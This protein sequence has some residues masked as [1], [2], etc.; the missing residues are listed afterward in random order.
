MAGSIKPLVNNRKELYYAWE[1]PDNPGELLSGAAL[2]LMNLISENIEGKSTTVRSEESNASLLPGE[3]KRVGEE[4]EGTLSFTARPGTQFEDM[5]AFMLMSTWSTELAISSNAITFAASDNSIS[6]TP[7]S[8]VQPRTWINLWRTGAVV[9]DPNVGRA[10]V[11]S[12]P[13]STKCILAYIVISDETAGTTVKVRGQFIRNGVTQ[14]TIMLERKTTDHATTPFQAL[15]ANVCESMQMS[16]GARGLIK[17]TVQV[18]GDWPMDKSASSISSETSL[19]ADTGEE[20]DASTNLVALHQNGSLTANL[21]SLEFTHGNAQDPVPLGGTPRLDSYSPGTKA[22]TGSLDGY[23]T[24]TETRAAWARNFADIELHVAL[25]SARTNRPTYI[26][27]FFLLKG[28]K[29]GSVGKEG[30]KGPS[31]LKLPFESNRPADNIWMQVCKLT[32]A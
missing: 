7:L 15:P 4:S 12:K 30:G 26:V 28:T 17:V 10:F 18:K 2:R 3:M 6:G 8:A 19:A 27:T 21:S 9:T 25:M 32:D 16:I 22:L 5:L 20:L 24:S 14:R 11:V 29:D 13:T 1:D 23:E 31:M